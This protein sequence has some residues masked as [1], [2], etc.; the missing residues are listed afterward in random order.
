MIW[1]EGHSHD[2]PVHVAQ[3]EVSLVGLEPAGHCLQSLM[4]NEAVSGVAANPALQ[5]QDCPSS[6][7]TISLGQSLQKKA[8]LS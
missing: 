8:V 5:T 4:K 2:P 3:A 7:A 6:L 1:P